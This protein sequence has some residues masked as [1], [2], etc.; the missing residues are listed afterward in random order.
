MKTCKFIIFL[1]VL[2]V[3]SKPHG[4]SAIGI[5]VY[6]EKMDIESEKTKIAKHYEINIRNPDSETAAFEAY[7]EDF[8]NAIK[9]SP[10]MFILGPGG[11][12]TL[13]LSPIYPTLQQAGFPKSLTLNIVSTDIKNNPVLVSA[14][15]KMK[16][17]IN[18]GGINPSK[19]D[20]GSDRFLAGLLALVLLMFTHLATH[21]K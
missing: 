16:I 4:A 19:I 3:F 18:Y 14:G 17:A 6:P 11:T 15:Y 10:K 8:P 9:I 13:E 20:F 7:F 21:K 5:S 12:K 2:T 1:V